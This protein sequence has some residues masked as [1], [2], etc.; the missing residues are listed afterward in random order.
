MRNLDKSIRRQ[1]WKAVVEE[2]QVSGLSSRKW[3]QERKIHNSTF[4]YWKKLFSPVSKPSRS[5]FLELSEE[6]KSRI[7]MELGGVKIYAESGF[8]ENL[9]VHCLK[10]LKKASSC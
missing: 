9:L 5:S 2:W 1:E 10:V 7:E 6:K 4:H 8:D 3:C